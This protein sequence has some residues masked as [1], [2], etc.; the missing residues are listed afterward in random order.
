MPRIS[1]W[2][3]RHSC[4]FEQVCSSQPI[5][6]A[7]P[8]PRFR[9]ISNAISGIGAA[10]D[11]TSLITFAVALAVAAAIPGPG[12]AA[13]VARALGTG[14]RPTLPMVIGLVA[15]DLIYLSAAALGLGMI[16]ATF[17]GVFTVIR[18]L[19]AAYLVFLAIRLLLVRPEVTD[20]PKCQSR[21]TGTR[22][23]G[24]FLAGFLVTLG[25]PKTILF[26]LALLPTIVD[27]GGLTLLGFAELAGV[28]LIVLTSVICGYAALAARARTLFESARARRILNRIAGV[29]M[30]GAAAAIATRS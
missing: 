9:F 19:G 5:L 23:T 4:P 8:W 3:T 25:N 12:V 14:F 26:Y 30:M 29:A 17:G 1:K 7:G 21:G 18:W 20:L 22:G 24:A 15:G 16:A 28:I 27:L 13:I 10:M 11:W 2:P 6:D